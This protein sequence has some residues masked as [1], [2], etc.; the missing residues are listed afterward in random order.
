MKLLLVGI[1][2]PSSSGKTTVA[3][4]LHLAL[5]QSTL[6]HLDDFY[7]ADDQIPMDLE[8]NVQNWDC[9]GAIDWTKFKAYIGEVRRTNGQ[10]LAME[11][12]EMDS[13]IKLSDA[14]VEEFSAQIRSLSGFHVVLVDGFMLYHDEEIL[15]LFDVKLFFHAPYKILKARREARQGY[16]TVAGFWADP[17]NYF[18]DIVWPEFEKSHRFLFENGNV[19]GS[20]NVEA[21]RMGLADAENDGTKSLKEL[22]TWSLSEI[23]KK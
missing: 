22:V 9:S 21:R 5:A 20:L 19:E 10:N 6:V 11:T 7:F 23:T 13:E 14:E 8:K 17:P 15:D 1:G 4:A 12:L 2:G 16:N 3:K 18:D